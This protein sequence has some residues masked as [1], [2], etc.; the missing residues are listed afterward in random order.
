MTTVGIIRQHI[1]EIAVGEPFTSTQFNG[2]GLV[3]PL[4]KLSRV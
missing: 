3:P 1:K 2:L 4:I